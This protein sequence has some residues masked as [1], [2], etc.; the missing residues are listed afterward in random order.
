MSISHRNWSLLLSVGLLVAITWQAILTQAEAASYELVIEGGRVMDPETGLDARRNIGIRDGRI[1]AISEESLDGNRVID[2]SGL[3]VAPGF[4]DTHM[5]G[6]TLFGSKLRLR[7][8]VTTSLD[9]EVGALNIEKW[10]AVRAGRWQTNYGVTVSHEF[11]RMVVLDGLEL[12]DPVDAQSLGPTRA[13]AERVDGT[14]HYALTEPSRDQ[15]AEIIERVDE[16]LRQGA[17]GLGTTIGYMIEGVSTEEM[18]ELQLAAARYGRGTYSHVRFLGNN[19]PPNEGTLGFAE[20]LANALALD[21][22]FLAIH[23]NNRGWWE[24]EAK[25]AEARSRGFNVWSEYYPYIS[26][27]GP[28]G[29]EFLKPEVLVPVWGLT[30]EDAM[31]DPATGEFYTQASYEAKRAEDPGYMVVL[32]MKQREPWLRQWLYRDHSSVG[33]DGMPTTDA[34]GEAIPW[35][36]PYSRFV[37]HPRTAGS[38][39]KVLR[40]AREEGV[41]LM[42]TLKQLSYFAALHLGEGGIESMRERGRIQEGMVADITV[43]DADRVTDNATH[44][45]GEQGSPSTGI[46]YVIVNGRVV[47]EDSKVLEVFP[48]QPIVYEPQAE[49]RFE[50]LGYPGDASVGGETQGG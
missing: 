43:F 3:V 39:A 4:I 35:D 29:S 38:H 23:D 34:N 2:A 30:Y 22:P 5:H 31:M 48:G 1:L 40:L 6:Q 27:S 42:H 10:Y 8:G 20:A 16:E 12:N 24:N 47:V 44:A 17:L 21:A 14:A 45:L 50:S 37:G 9:L 25:L 32:F 49:G 13:A 18:W 15:L 36:A 11:V 46:P 41:A 19:S 26:G 33:S 7:D 28:I